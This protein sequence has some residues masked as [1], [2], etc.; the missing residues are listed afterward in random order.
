MKAK[1]EPEATNPPFLPPPCPVVLMSPE[2]ALEITNI[3]GGV[4]VNPLTNESIPGD[5]TVCTLA[6][7]NAVLQIIA[8]QTGQQLTAKLPATGQ[9]NYVPVVPEGIGVVFGTG[10]TDVNVYI[11]VNAAGQ[12]VAGNCEELIRAMN[13]RGYGVPGTWVY[14]NG[15]NWVFS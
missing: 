13:Y 10:P 9:F 3:G 11:A 8:I 14:K 1:E 5:D 4:Y 15:L 7:A 2:G 6:A 12:E